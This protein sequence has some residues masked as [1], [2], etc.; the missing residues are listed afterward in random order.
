MN[1]N[2]I[3]RTEIKRSGIAQ[4]RIAAKIGVSEN[5][6]IRWLRYPLTEEKIMRIKTAIV[7]L[8]EEM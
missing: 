5:T 3:I 6:L 4:W 7:A 8:C 1:E 2:Q